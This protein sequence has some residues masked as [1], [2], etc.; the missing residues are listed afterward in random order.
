MDP[1]R[2]MS[3]QG[4]EKPLLSRRTLLKS[5]GFAPLLLRSA[6]LFGSSFLSGSIRASS[7]QQP[8]FPF[9]DVRFKPHYPAQSSLADVLRLVTPGSDEYTTEK[10]AF[11]IDALLNQWSQS[12]QRSAH[13]LADLLKLLSATLEAS[14]FSPVKEVPLRSGYG[15]DATKRQFGAAVP[16]SRERFLK[17]FQ[18]WLGP[19]SK[20]ET[21]EFEIYRIHEIANAPLTLQLEIRYD[22]VAVRKDHSSRGAGWLLAN[23]VV[24]Q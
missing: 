5:V 20:V 9:T 17:E 13:D 24:A 7:G 2:V 12:L 1:L 6:P 10:Y 16:C 22:F 14:S 23:R 3:H 8:A 21:A 11:E 19:V 4:N 18:T 15:I